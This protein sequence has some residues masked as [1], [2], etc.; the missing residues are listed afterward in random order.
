MAKPKASKSSKLNDKEAACSEGS[1]GDSDHA[2][3]TF[4]EVQE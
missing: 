3:M 1:K 4:G 2:E